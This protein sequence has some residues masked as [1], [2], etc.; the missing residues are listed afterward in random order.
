MLCWTVLELYGKLVHTDLVI[1]AK[2][3]GQAASSGNAVLIATFAS[4]YLCT[5]GT[6]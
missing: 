2:N 1:K 3:D 5:Y 6:F 4:F